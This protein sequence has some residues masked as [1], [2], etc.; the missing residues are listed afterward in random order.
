MNFDCT[1]LMIWPGV[2]WNVLKLTGGKQKFAQIGVN[3]TLLNLQGAKYF[4]KV[5][6]QKIFKL[7]GRNSKKIFYRRKS[8]ITYITGDKTLLTLITIINLLRDLVIFLYLGMKVVIILI[9]VPTFL[10]RKHRR[11]WQK[12]YS[13][14]LNI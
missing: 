1:T 9:I 11:L 5:Q 12:R 14:I 6:N 2:N 10:K 13:Q 7:Q 3:R 8:K 4:M